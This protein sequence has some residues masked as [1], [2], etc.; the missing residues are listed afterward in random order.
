MINR[1]VG[2]GLLVV[3]L[4]VGVAGCSTR[5]TDFTVLSTKNVDVSRVAVYERLAQ[6][7]EGDDTAHTIL[8]FPTG[9]PDMKEAI[10]RAIEQVPGGV[11]LVDG[12]LYR[13]WWYIPLIYGQTSFVVE[14]SVLV[15]PKIKKVE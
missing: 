8:V 12:V 4:M 10:D 3:A 15:D 6:R 11:C 1:Q 13:K 14:G 5:I 2:L 7:V 9:R